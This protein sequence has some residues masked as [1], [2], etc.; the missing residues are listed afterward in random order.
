MASKSVPSVVFGIVPVET[1]S[2]NDF[3][4][5]FEDSKFQV[6]PRVNTLAHILSRMVL[7]QSPFC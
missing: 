3:A 5:V 2:S 4:V 1:H 6:Q 7:D